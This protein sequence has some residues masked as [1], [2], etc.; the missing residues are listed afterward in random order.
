MK[1]R[2]LCEERSGWSWWVHALIW[3]TFLAAVLPLFELA[4]GNVGSREGAMPLGVAVLCL[5]LGFGIPSL[6][7][8][9][10]GQ[11]KTRVTSE[12]IDIRWGFAE[13]I[14]KKIPL[15]KVDG[16]EAVTYSP[17]REFGGWGIR[18]GMNKK[19]GWT[20][21]GNRALV[22]NLKDGTRFYLGSDKP[23]RILQ[24]VQSATKR[25]EV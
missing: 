24:W 17:I 2:A 18:V 25:S 8:F 22:L 16:A 10:M 12:E 1:T 21:R 14:K 15:E 23:E 3:L 11:L 19:K 6:F 20:I 5:S 13:V 7:Y 4:N 9:F